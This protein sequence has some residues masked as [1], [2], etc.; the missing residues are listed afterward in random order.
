MDS[1]PDPVVGN[2]QLPWMRDEVSTLATSLPE[3]IEEESNQITTVVIFVISAILTITL[4]FVMA[5]FIDCR[6]EKLQR[7]EKKQKPRRVFRLKL[8]V[9][10][11]RAVRDDEAT[12]ADKMQESEPTPSS[13]NHVV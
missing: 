9:A 1:G 5:V 8:P 2:G 3:I 11:G 12:F 4:L 10:L 6:Q 13:S 7:M